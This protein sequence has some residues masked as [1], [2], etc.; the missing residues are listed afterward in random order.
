MNSSNV[1]TEV[2]AAINKPEKIRHLQGNT[3]LFQTLGYC[4]GLVGLSTDRY[5]DEAACVVLSDFIRTEFGGHTTEEVGLAFKLA[6]AGKLDCETKHFHTFSP[7][8][9]ADVMNAYRAYAVTLKKEADTNNKLLPPSQVEAIPD[10]PDDEW[11]QIV[12]DG[13]KMLKNWEFI[14]LAIYDLLKLDE[15]LTREEKLEIH[16]LVLKHINKQRLDLIY[17]KEYQ[18][19]PDKTQWTKDQCKKFAVG[20][21]FNKLIQNKQ[22]V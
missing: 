11:L 3:E 21:Y 8:Y 20:Q 7:M 13:Y 18:Q 14:P 9:F 6:A 17:E 19:R 4:F 22:N 5:P 15:K 12:F 2:L 10:I 16:S 1:Q